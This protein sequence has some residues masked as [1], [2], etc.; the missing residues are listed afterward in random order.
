MSLTYEQ[1]RGQLAE[2]NY[3]YPMSE[4]TVPLVQALLSDLI[5]AVSS[6]KDLETEHEITAEELRLAVEEINRV[7]VIENPK[8]VREKNE[9]HVKL[10]K[11]REEYESNLANARKNASESEERAMKLELMVSQMK[12]ENKEFSSENAILRTRIDQL[13][14]VPPVDNEIYPPTHVLDKVGAPVP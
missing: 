8:L 6:Y 3:L 5:A 1:V 7:G 14:M 13:L 2:L 10:V 12:Y 9:L 4:D 11:V